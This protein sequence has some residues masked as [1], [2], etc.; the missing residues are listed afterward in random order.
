MTNSLR[1]RQLPHGQLIRGRY[2]PLIARVLDVAAVYTA[3]TNDRPYRH[4]LTPAQAHLEI[5]RNAGSQFDPE[6]VARFFQEKGNGT[7]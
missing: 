1:I 6:V 3:L 2:I 7:S 4:G 5:E